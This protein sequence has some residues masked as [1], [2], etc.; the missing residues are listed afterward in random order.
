MKRPTRST[1]IALTLAAAAGAAM[2]HHSAVQFDFTKQVS[3]KGKVTHFRA[4]NPH[5]QLKVEVTDSKGTRVIEFEG[6]STNNM[7]R[8][9]YRKGMI[10]EGDIIT[11]YA[12][13]LKSGEDGGYVVSADAADGTHFGMRSQRL[14]A[15]DAAKLRQAAEGR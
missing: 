4:I 8:N 9:G 6:H 7:Y 13:P 2:A 12:A 1:L 3:Y 11:V 14:S 15:E 10:N 5:M